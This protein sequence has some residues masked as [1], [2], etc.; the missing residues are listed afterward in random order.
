[1]GNIIIDKTVTRPHPLLPL[2][3]E[4]CCRARDV[5]TRQHRTETILSYRSIYLQEPKR[6]ELTPFLAAEH[7]GRV[8]DATERPPRLAKVEYFVKCGKQSQYCEAIVDIQTEKQITVKKFDP[9]F[10][11]SLNL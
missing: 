10:P 3:A 4:E 8:T 5:V 9:S 6:A 7:D 11:I 1:M 2:S